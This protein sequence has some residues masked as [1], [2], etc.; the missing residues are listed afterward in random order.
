[1]KRQKITIALVL[2]LTFA[3]YAL[4]AQWENLSLT[5]RPTPCR[6]ADTRIEEGSIAPNEIRI[7]SV[8]PL[9]SQA[10][11]GTAN[12]GVPSDVKA[13]KVM[14][15]GQTT[16]VDGG[17]MRVFNANASALG[18]YSSLNYQTKNRFTSTHLDVPISGELLLA[19]HTTV[20]THVIVDVIGYYKETEP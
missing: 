20:R 17:H 3:P 6:V 13:I 4:Q 12:C 9:L 19:I 11:G 18:V 7:I 1:M 2:A 10:Q 14:V 8:D 5:L 15:A 16:E